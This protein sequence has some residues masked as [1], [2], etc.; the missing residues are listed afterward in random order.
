[1]V[2]SDNK[3]QHEPLL[4]G[5]RPG[6]TTIQVDDIVTQGHGTFHEARDGDDIPDARC[7]IRH[8]CSVDSKAK[9]H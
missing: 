4:N 2:A 8:S 7:V 9:D 3:D 1:M 5:D 6:E